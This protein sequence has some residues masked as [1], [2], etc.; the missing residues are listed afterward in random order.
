[1]LMPLPTSVITAP[2]LRSNLKTGSTG[3]FSQSTGPPPAVPAPQ[4]P[5]DAQ[6]LQEALSRLAEQARL[7]PAFAR[8][9][10]RNV[11][12]HREPGLRA[13]TMTVSAA[14]LLVTHPRSGITDVQGYFAA[15]RARGDRVTLAVPGIGGIA[16]PPPAPAAAPWSGALIAARSAERPAPVFHSSFSSQAGRSSTSQSRIQ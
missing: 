15:L 9:L 2:V 7:T 1:M 5:H 12:E 8:W 4:R 10:E 3:L 13:V 11:A 16:P 14:Q 6:S